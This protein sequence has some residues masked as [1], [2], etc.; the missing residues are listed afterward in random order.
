MSR[1]AEELYF[2]PSVRFADLDWTGRLPTQFQQRILGFYLNPAVALAEARHVF[3]SGILAV[4]AIDALSLSVTGSKSNARITGFCRKYIPELAA[5]HD[6]E[7][8]CEHFRNGLVHEA[9][10]KDGSEFSTE[11]DKI[12]V[13]RHDY[14]AVNPRLLSIQVANVLKDYVGFLYKNP[15]AKLALARKLKRTF[16][17]E[18]EH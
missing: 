10:V 9:R 16:R 18:L 2:A 4:C 8:F 11:I 3:A 1:I 7:M 13:V 5:E 15:P 14:L 17:Y 12:V 6:A